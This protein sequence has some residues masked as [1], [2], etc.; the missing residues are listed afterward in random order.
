[1][2]PG[3]IDLLSLPANSR[4]RSVGLRHAG[5][6]LV[7]TVLFAATAA[8]IYRGWT[9]RVMADGQ[10]R[11][12]A[13]I[14]LAMSVVA[15]VSMVIAGSLGWALVQTHHVGIKPA[16]TH[17]RRPSREPEL[18]ALDAGMAYA[19]PSATIVERLPLRAR[20]T[21]SQSLAH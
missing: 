13:T 21:G 1:V 10:Y 19:D 12:D 18:D 2:I 4:A 11:F 14:P 5:F 8:I 7:A 6:N 17:A 3:V 20:P 15:W 9:H 16:L